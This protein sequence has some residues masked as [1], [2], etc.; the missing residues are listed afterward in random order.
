L[1]VLDYA[2][3]D[4]ELIPNVAMVEGKSDYYLLAYYQAVIL[5]TPAAERLKLMPGGGAGTLDDLLQ[6]YIGWSRPFVALLDS[7]VA[8][9]KEALRYTEKFGAIVDRHLVLL[10]EAS[11]KGSARG[12]ESLLSDSDRIRFQQVIDP[13]SEVY[14][15]KTFALGVQEALVARR[16]VKV[17]VT[18]QRALGR[19]LDFLGQRLD[20]ITADMIG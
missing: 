15:K 10:D 6:L 7:D 1:D 17:T 19:T 14:K 12:I 9:K 20:D 5:N 2:P 13:D 18:A 11:G 8:G 3:S 4:L 16:E